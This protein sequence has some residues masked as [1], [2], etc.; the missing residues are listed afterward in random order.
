MFIYV[1]VCVYICWPS[2]ENIMFYS[3]KLFFVKYFSCNIFFK[4][5]SYDY[6]HVS[7]TH[8]K[9]ITSERLNNLGKVTLV[10]RKKL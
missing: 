8:K 9:P 3:D 5:Y 10:S 4:L 1:C 2:L 7:F 6:S